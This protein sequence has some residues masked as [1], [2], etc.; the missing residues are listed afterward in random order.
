MKINLGILFVLVSLVLGG[1]D[2]YASA[3]GSGGF[4]WW[5]WLVNWWNNHNG[6]GGKSVPELSASYLPV[7]L[8]LLAG[9]LGIGIE[10]KRRS[11][12]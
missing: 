10:R 12:K 9:I 1:S 2:V 3:G 6:G 4:N 5:E 8:A 7:A 11:K